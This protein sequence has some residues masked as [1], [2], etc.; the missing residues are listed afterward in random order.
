MSNVVESDT[1]LF[2]ESKA[3][4]NGPAG[5]LNLLKES[6]HINLNDWLLKSDDI[7]KRVEQWLVSANEEEGTKD[8]ISFGI[9]W[10]NVFLREPQLT[11][12]LFFLI[13]AR[14]SMR[15]SGFFMTLVRIA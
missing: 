8:G 5:L 13:V 3:I 6:S 14:S 7:K 15:K 12:C 9:I 10:R 4:A 1:I 11:Y 2:N